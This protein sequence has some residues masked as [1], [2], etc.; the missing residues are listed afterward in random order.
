MQKSSLHESGRSKSGF[1]GTV[2]A[3]SR[4]ELLISGC[5]TAMLRCY[6][7]S[8]LIL[9]TPPRSC[10]FKTVAVWVLDTTLRGYYSFFFGFCKSILE[11]AV[12]FMVKT[13]G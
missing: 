8:G 5:L 12:A 11:A 6:E 10:F 1:G 9:A 3:G 7:P 4:F 2:V 13:N